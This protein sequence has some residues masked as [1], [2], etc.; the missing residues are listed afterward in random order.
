MK[1]YSPAKL[2]LFFRILSKR[3][4]GFHEI[5]SLMQAISLCD[6][7][8]FAIAK[9]DSL[10]C[11]NPEF[12]TDDRNFVSKA[13]AL[14]RKKTG[15]SDPI[16]IHVEKNIPVEG[17]LGGG[18]GNIA[19]T[20][21]AMNQLSGLHLD[22]EILAKWAGEISSDAPF[23]F[24]R[25]TGYVTG[26]GEK[27]KSLPLLPKQDLY[28]AKPK[29]AGLSTPLVYKHCMPSAVFKPK[30]LLESALKGK[31]QSINDLELPA[32]RL[33]PELLTF[34]KE[35]LSLGFE[36]VCMTGSGTT[37]FCFGNIENPFLPE[38]F[39]WKISFLFRS[40]NDWYVT[41]R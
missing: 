9:E 10:I 41:N 1:L 34:K 13:R 21:Y 30:D 4:D 11:K 25:G 36:R 32:F 27:V 40:E 7:L 29:G 3:D 14:F 37:F 15:F 33:R 16:A 2:N 17:G 6:I 31:L 38:T 20:L 5:A 39:F 8:D 19:T 23:F 35:L 12:P 26:R 18:S 24:S 28:L 22:E